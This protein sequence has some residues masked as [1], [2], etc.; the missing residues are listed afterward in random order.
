MTEKAQQESGLARNHDYA[1]IDYRE[2]E[3]KESREILIKN[4]W[5]MS[6]GPDWVRGS[7]DGDVDDNEVTDGSKTSSK[8]VKAS[9]GVTG[10]FWMSVNDVL[11]NFEVFYINW[12]ANTLF[13]YR[14]EIHYAWDLSPSSAEANSADGSFIRNPQHVMTTDSHSDVWLLLTKHFQDRPRDEEGHFAKQPVEYISLYV[15]HSEGKRVPLSRG[16]AHHTPF[17]DAPQSLMKLGINP[18]TP[19]TIVTA[20]EDMSERPHAFTLYAFSD[21]KLTLVEATPKYRERTSIRGSWTTDTA[22]GNANLA[23]YSKNPQYSLRL[24]SASPVCILLETKNEAVKIHVRLVHGR[25]QRIT[26]IASRDIIVDSGNYCP[27]TALA[28]LRTELNA[29][30]YTVVC[31]TYEA[32]ELAD[33]ALTADSNVNASLNPILREG[34]GRFRLPLADASFASGVRKVACPVTPYRM[35]RLFIKATHGKP[36]SSPAGSSDPSA[37]ATPISPIRIT[38]EERTS[39]HRLILIASAGGQ[40][41]DAAAGVKTEDVDLNPY[42]VSHARHGVEMWLVLER[43]GGFAGVGKPE[44]NIKV[45]LFSDVEDPLQLGVW[46]E[47]E[48]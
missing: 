8:T 18:A 41:S 29:G 40:F 10:A 19:C 15:F 34:A 38:I 17:G 22:G 46:R 5:M 6:H 12:D 33:F 1:V 42:M 13:K 14:T 43:M 2:G 4:P 3:T 25:G 44:E 36:S 24:P 30:T 35:C 31:G 20:A 48:F 16:S 9:G 32:G 26:A 47:V 45:D 7:R 21:V 37:S 23:S 39:A 27:N 28:E 11:Q